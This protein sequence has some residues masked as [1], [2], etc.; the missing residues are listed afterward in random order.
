MGQWRGPVR[1]QRQVVEIL[2]R[3]NSFW[4]HFLYWGR[5]GNVLL[6]TCNLK[7]FERKRGIKS[8]DGVNSI[9]VTQCLVH[10]SVTEQLW[11]H[12]CLRL[13]DFIVKEGCVQKSTRELKLELKIS[14]RLRLLQRCE[15]SL[16]HKD[17]WYPAVCAPRTL[18]LLYLWMPE[19]S[20]EAM[21][22]Y[23]IQTDALCTHR[24]LPSC[25]LCDYLLIY[26]HRRGLICKFQNNNMLIWTVF[27]G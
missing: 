1:T 26:S 3:Q 15:S 24:I 2:L 6:L 5:V 16:K 17:C 22:D 10:R 19:D 14:L 8:W 21:K 7:C 9:N 20:D 11:L 25:F 23:W 27:S 18:I 12:V 13:W 4:S